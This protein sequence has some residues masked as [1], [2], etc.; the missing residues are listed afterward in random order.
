MTTSEAPH[1][2]HAHRE[3]VDSI[4]DET[5]RVFQEAAEFA[6]KKW[7]AAILLSLARGATRFSQ[8]VDTVEGISPRLLS[9][10]LR[11]LEARRLIVREVIP[12][13]PVQ[14]TYRLAP[15]GSDLIR[16]LNP[17]VQWAWQHSA[18]ES[19]RPGADEPR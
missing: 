2:A 14:V 18:P 6:G 7:T 11:E 13:T 12:T 3:H 17:L 10:R 4:D 19:A 5:C 8:I 16:I 9:V 15:S 1:S